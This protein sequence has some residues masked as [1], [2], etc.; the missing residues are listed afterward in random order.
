MSS[1][2]GRGFKFDLKWLKNLLWRTIQHM[3]ALMQYIRDTRGEMRHVAWPTQAQTIIFTALVIVISI[4]TALYLGF[5]DFIFTRILEM[6][7]T[8]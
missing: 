6:T 5:L 8:R 7:I 3:N 1:S 4:A 2:P